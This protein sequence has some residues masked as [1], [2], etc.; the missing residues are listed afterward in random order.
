MPII[1]VMGVSGAGK[2]TVGQALA[3][4]LG[5]RFIE[6]D[7]FHPEANIIRM[8]AGVPLTD[9]D[10][11]PWLERLA[12]EM[13]GCVKHRRSAVVSC[14]AL[15]AA[16]RRTLTVDEDTVVFVYLKAER[17]LLEKRVATRTGHFM[18][19]SLLESQLAAL[20]EPGDA[21]VID[22]RRPITAMVANI[23]QALRLPANERL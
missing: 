15:K 19:G 8:R 22:A 3:S 6:G 18:P 21:L 16:Y 11:E 23:C 12:A 9:A 4:A 5:W 14:S 10:R 13:R 7:D 1:V 2:T 17:E 20:E